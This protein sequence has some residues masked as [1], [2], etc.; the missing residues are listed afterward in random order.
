MK[1]LFLL[2]I[3]GIFASAKSCNNTIAKDCKELHE[4]GQNC[5]GV[6]TIKP[7]HLPAFEAYCD[8]SKGV[9]YTVLQRRMDGTV[10]FY[11]DWANYLKGF[12]DLKGEFWLG[13]DKIHRIT[14]SCNGSLRIDMEDFAGEKRSAFYSQFSLKGADEKYSLKVSGYSGNAGDSLTQHNGRR[15]TTHDQDNDD[16]QTVNCAFAS[17]GAWWYSSCHFSN[18]NGLYL[19]GQHPSNGNGVNWSSWKGINYSLRITEMKVLRY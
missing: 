12:G 6:Y 4:N 3:F 13:L 19:A 18:L 16:S 9:G 2:C 1:S 7:D 8:M 14:T 11:Q 15:F 10:N 17:R 5:S